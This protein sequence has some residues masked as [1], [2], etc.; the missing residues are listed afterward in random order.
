MRPYQRVRFELNNEVQ[1]VLIQFHANFLCVE[2]FHHETG[3]SGPLFNDLYGA[4]NVQVDRKSL[5]EIQ[6]LVQWIEREESAQFVAHREMLVSCAKMLLIVATRL[7]ADG[8]ESTESRS[9]EFRH[10]V[11][12]QLKELLETNY[13]TS[14]SPADYATA[15]HMTP[16]S[17]GRIVREH[18]GRTLSDLIRERVLTHAKWELLHTLRP[19]KEIAFEVGFQDELYFSRIFKKSTGVSP[20]FY[21]EFETEIRGGSNLSMLSGQSSMPNAQSIPDHFHD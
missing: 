2:T 10:P 3:C 16:K 4:P 18:L 11:I 1:G 21:R 9:D 20:T 5:K 15:L 14:H 12:V 8:K 19:V 17:L 6:T 13:R 7:K